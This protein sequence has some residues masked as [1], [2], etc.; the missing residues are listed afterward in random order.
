MR[1]FGGEMVENLM[2]RFGLEED[3]PL[4]SGLVSKAIENAQKRMEGYNFDTR[5]HLVEYDDVMNKH[6]EIIYTMRRRILEGGE[7]M[8]KWLL[9]KLAPFSAEVKRIWEEREREFGEVWL[10]V[11]QF[12]T[13]Q[14]F[15]HLWLEH[16]TTMT[17]LQRDVG[18]RGNTDQE[19]LAIYKTDGRQYFDRLVGEIWGTVT[20]RLERVEIKKREDVPEAQRPRRLVLQHPTSPSGLRGTGPSAQLAPG[21]TE[22]ASGG[23]TVERKGKKIGRND[24]CPCGAIN[25]ETGKPYK[26]KKC[27][28]INAPYHKG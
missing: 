9:E 13:L 3:I 7:V 10:K 5:K 16:I 8:K 17:E 18:L 2:D 15:D 25:P 23:G 26:Y 4:E 20:D 19:R 22:S 14:A 28:L 24:P 6:R 1:K 27:G 12:Y 11:A 21:E